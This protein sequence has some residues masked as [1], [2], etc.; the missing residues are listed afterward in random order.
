MFANYVGSLPSYTKPETQ[1][2]ATVGTGEVGLTK[3][4]AHD[5]GAPSNGRIYS[6]R[7]LVRTLKF[8]VN[9]FR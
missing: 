7:I 8:R 9:V 3:Q 5:L 1:Q 6:G 2:T 4:L